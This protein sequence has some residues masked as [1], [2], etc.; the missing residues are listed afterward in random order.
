MKT[1]FR[2]LTTGSLT[3]FLHRSRLLATDMCTDMKCASKSSYKTYRR[4]CFFVVDDATA[5]EA[6]GAQGLETAATLL[7]P[8]ARLCCF[9]TVA[10]VHE[11]NARADMTPA[12]FERRGVLRERKELRQR[13][14]KKK[15]SE[16]CVDTSKNIATKKKKDSSCFS[17]FSAWQRVARSLHTCSLR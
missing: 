15:A 9:E 6:I 7:L 16:V 4:C 8:P 2:R 11:E 5:V 10:E 12:A 1:R 17:Q 14:I 3:L 13:R